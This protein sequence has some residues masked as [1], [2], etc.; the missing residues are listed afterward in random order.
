MYQQG[1]TSADPDGDE[2]SNRQDAPESPQ[3]PANLLRHSFSQLEEQIKSLQDC[4]AEANSLLEVT[5]SMG[6]FM[7]QTMEKLNQFQQQMEE[8]M[9]AD[10]EREAQEHQELL[11]KLFDNITDGEW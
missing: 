11:G 10:L 5:K 1:L 9:K 2:R 7:A 6:N 4:S 8:K 3:S